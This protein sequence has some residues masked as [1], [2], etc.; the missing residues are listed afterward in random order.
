M[1]IIDLYDDISF[2]DLIWFLD[3]IQWRHGVIYHTFDM[4]IPSHELLS[5]NRPFRPHIST[6]HISR[7]HC[8]RIE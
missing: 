5:W 7:P 6:S 2:H 4:Q 8:V 3:Y 1:V